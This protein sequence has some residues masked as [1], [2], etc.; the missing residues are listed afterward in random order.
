MQVL[1]HSQPHLLPLKR[2][3]KI[4][5]QLI[6]LCMALNHRRLEG[7]TKNAKRVKSI[8]FQSMDTGILLL[9]IA[10]KPMNIDNINVFNPCLIYTGISGQILGKKDANK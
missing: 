4:S 3:A 2:G 7:F 8:A 9:I 10:L 5:L 6:T 1:R